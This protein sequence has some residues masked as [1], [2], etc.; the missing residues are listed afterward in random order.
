MRGDRRLAEVL[1]EIED[2]LAANRVLAAAR[3]ALLR[4]LVDVGAGNE[5]LLPGAGDHDHADA[6]S[7]PSVDERGLAARRASASSWRSGPRDG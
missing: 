3:R 7:R 6:S 1:D 2:L 4:Q 5:R